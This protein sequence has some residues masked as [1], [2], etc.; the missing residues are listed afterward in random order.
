MKVTAI[1]D[2]TS[3]ILV[4]VFTFI[5]S[6]PA[7]G[8]NIRKFS[9]DGTTTPVIEPGAP[10]GSFALSGFDNVN[11]FNGNLNFS[12]PLLKIG[13]RGGA[14]FTLGLKIE[15]KWRVEYYRTPTGYQS[16]GQGCV[17]PIW[18]PQGQHYYPNPNWWSPDPGFGPGILVG[19]W[20]GIS[21]GS[22]TIGGPGG[23]I[24]TTLTF[25]TND[26]SEIV[27]RDDLTNGQ[28][29]QLTS[30]YCSSNIGNRGV[31]WHSVNGEGATF[32]SDTVIRDSD[33]T[34]EFYP[35]GYLMTRDGTRSRID[36]GNL[37][38][39]RD[40]NGNKVSFTYGGIGR[41][42]TATDSLNRQ[43]SISYGSPTVISFSGFGG[44]VRTIEIGY[45]NLGNVLRYDQSLKTYQQLWPDLPEGGS[46][47]FNPTETPSYVKMPDDRYYYFKYNSYRE[48]A[49]IELPTGGAIDYDWGGM[50]W[51]TWPDANTTLKEIRRW[52]TEKRIYPDGGTG[53]NFTTR[54]TF[55]SSQGSSPTTGTLT[56]YDSGNAAVDRDRLIS[57]L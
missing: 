21:R 57:T 42:L 49:R 53:S 8:Q 34:G 40:R 36:N 44:T 18:G 38:W 4:A 15:K 2:R 30:A 50:I 56:T 33:M 47:T 35:S 52:V 5:I 48:L 39:I 28:P 11:L 32:I 31:N 27:L 23:S 45:D 19:R 54:Q 13:G 37:T 46:A 6:V 20:G 17:Q 3:F 24:I 16:C 22:C 7:H 29:T 26:G 43:I 25:I 41:M 1:I 14:G 9:T 12:L 10:A 55:S 51:L